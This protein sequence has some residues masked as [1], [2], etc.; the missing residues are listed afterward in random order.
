MKFKLVLAICLILLLAPS[1]MAWGASNN[2]ACVDDESGS[3][4]TSVYSS[5]MGYVYYSDYT[6]SGLTMTTV[7]PG[8]VNAATLANYDTLFLFAVNPSVFSAAQKTDIVNFVKGGGKLV[9][10]DSEDPYPGSWSYSWL[11][12]GWTSS[13][14]GP[15][16]ASGTLTIV[17]ENTLSS[18]NSASPYYINAGYL[19]SSTDAVGDANV[20]TSFIPSDWCVDCTARNTLG[21]TGPTHVYTN[22]ASGKFGSG[23]II[24]MGLDWDYAG[25]YSGMNPAS[26]GYYL[27]KF[28]LQ[29]FTTS[30]LPCGT[31]PPT[32]LDVDKVADKSVYNVGDTVIFTITVH[33]PSTIY[34][35]YNVE[36]V[37]YP[38]PEVSLSQTTYNLGDIA[39]GQTVTQEIRGTAVANGCD[40][41]NSAVATGYYNGVPYFTGGDTVTFD[42]GTCVP[43][44]EFPSFVVPATMIVGLLAIASYLRRKN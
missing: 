14:P 44:P 27:K 7:E 8:N 30:S 3:S 20:F 10:W 19:G 35:A 12:S 34:T 24:Y 36:L 6:P 4:A 32:T 23:I 33:N 37:D 31:P 16:G 22:S 17:E 26:S 21:I 38:P 1:V 39:P 29:E 9:I 40:V 11:P 28:L 2:I 13:V 18:A 42:I 41:D 43:T 25:S 5:D 15:Q